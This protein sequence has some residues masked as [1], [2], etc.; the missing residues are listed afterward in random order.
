M[1]QM[2][3]SNMSN[4]KIEKLNHNLLVE[5]QLLRTAVNGLPNLIIGPALTEIYRN[6][7]PITAATA[8]TKTETATLG[9]SLNTL[10]DGLP[11][12]IKNETMNAVKIEMAPHLQ[13]LNARID[14]LSAQFSKNQFSHDLE[15]SQLEIS[16]LSVKPN[17][18]ERSQPETNIDYDPEM[19]FDQ[20]KN[21]KPDLYPVW[22]KLFT[23][24]KAS[25]IEAPN[26]NC[27]TWT[28]RE[29]R[30]FRAYVKLLCRGHILDIGCGPYADPVYLQGLPADHLSAL[31]PLDLVAEPWFRVTKGLNEFIP[32]ADNSF[33]TVINAT[34]LDHVIDVERALEET[35]RVLTK[36]GQFII[37]Y[38]NIKTAPNPITNYDGPLDDYH[39][40]HTNDEWFLP[41]LDRYFHTQDRKVFAASDTTDNVFACLVPKF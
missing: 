25:Y 37:W 40:F 35:A 27:S 3:D 33:D 19:V 22:E 12:L 30:A 1:S 23:A 2:E 15:F 7:E 17:R 10:I 36:N 29:A 39:L 41:L 16:A 4:N 21:F 5:L 24:A 6:L 28:S 8:Q 26:F 31:E 13:T 14:N 32:F 20:L 9:A 38:A 18:S 11:A 34:S